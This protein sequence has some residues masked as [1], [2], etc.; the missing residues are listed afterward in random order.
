MS[1][2]GWAGA[3]V[4]V[5]LVVAAGLVVAAAGLVIAA[6]GLLVVAAGLVAVAGVGVC[7]KAEEVA[8]A[9]VRM[10]ARLM[11]MRRSWRRTYREVKLAR[12][13]WTTRFRL[14]NLAS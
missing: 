4:V 13:P 14:A 8:R 3:V 9:T 1:A 5:V 2:L 7:A 11:F 10:S 12:V 6:A